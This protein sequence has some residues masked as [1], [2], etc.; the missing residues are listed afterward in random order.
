M[1]DTFFASVFFFFSGGPCLLFA[2]AFPLVCFSAFCFLRF[3]LLLFRVSASLL[4]ASSL[5]ASRCLLVFACAFAFLG[6][7]PTSRIGKAC[8]NVLPC[9]SDDHCICMSPA[10]NHR[11][12]HHTIMGIFTGPLSNFANWEGMSKR[13]AL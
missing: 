7:F 1:W 3:L 5:F 13:S 4:F 2:F 12:D 6:L 10:Q 8:E 9:D 11:H